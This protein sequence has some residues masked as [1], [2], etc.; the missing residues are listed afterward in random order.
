MEAIS[1]GVLAMRAYIEKTRSLARNAVMGALEVDVVW[2]E[3]LA[4]SPDGEGIVEWSRLREHYDYQVRDVAALLS[5]D[6]ADEKDL[7]R[8]ISMRA[9]RESMPVLVRMRELV[10]NATS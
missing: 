2:A 3:W 8:D 1:A 10:S 9:E 5:V 6:K 7:F 4:D